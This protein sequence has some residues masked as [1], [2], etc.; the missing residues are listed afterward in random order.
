MPHLPRPTS[1]S[2]SVVL[3]LSSVFLFTSP[4]VTVTRSG[5]VTTGGGELGGDDEEDPTAESR[6]EPSEAESLLEPSEVESRLDPSEPEVDLRRGGTEGA[7]GEGG[8]KAAGMWR[9]AVM[10]QSSSDP[11]SVC[12][13]RWQVVQLVRIT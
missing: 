3:C 9:E 11:P 5:A 1:L 10:T 12:G 13:L 4:A 2:I 8:E 6:F 7:R